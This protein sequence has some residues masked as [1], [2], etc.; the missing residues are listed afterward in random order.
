[1]SR[2]ECSVPAGGTKKI[3]WRCPVCRTV[4]KY[5]PKAPAAGFLS[6]VF[7]TKRNRDGSKPSLL[8][9]DQ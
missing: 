6:A 2:H 3:Q 5:D 7:G 9:R 1:M 4:W 8:G